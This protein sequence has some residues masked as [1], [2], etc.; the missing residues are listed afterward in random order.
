MS[1]PKESQ[2]HS[3]SNAAVRSYIDQILFCDRYIDGKKELTALD[4]IVALAILC[5]VNRKA[6]ATYVDLLT[7]AKRLGVKHPKV[8][9]AA[10]RL[11]ETKH[12]GTRKQR[13]RAT[14]LLIP[15]PKENER[16][17]GRHKAAAG[18]SRDT[19]SQ[20]PS[21][22]GV[23]STRGSKAFLAARGEMIWRIVFDRRL[24][25]AE[26][27][28]G[29]GYLLQIDPDTCECDSGQRYMAKALDLSRRILRGAIKKLQELRY[30]AITGTTSDGSQIVAFDIVVDHLVDHSVDH[31]VGHSEYEKTRQMGTS[32]PNLMNLVNL[33][34]LSSGQEGERYDS[35]IRG[36]DSS[37]L[38][39]FPDPAAVS[40]WRGGVYA[41]LLDE[42][43]PLGLVHP[44]EIARL[45]ASGLIVHNGE[46]VE[47]TDLGHAVG[48]PAQSTS[49]KEAA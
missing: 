40:L 39:H 38:V 44:N 24:S 37:A 5:Y 7:V 2:P 14:P 15:I 10:D 41:H 19:A 17:A 1:A 11:V 20:M 32:D 22:S 4:K 13:D 6:G 3:L 43:N 27:V 12:L 21:L 42:S 29:L 35:V 48:S 23:H 34:N 18:C 16:S 9:A 45:I 31:L 33:S 25:I 46:R 28:V 8:K 47:I 30:V 26:R 36:E 49:A